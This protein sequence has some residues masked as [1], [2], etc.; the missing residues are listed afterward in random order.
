MPFKNGGSIQG[1]ASLIYEPIPACTYVRRS[2]GI[3]ISCE[4]ESGDMT[5]LVAAGSTEGIAIAADSRRLN[6]DD[7]FN[8]DEAQKV[9]HD[10]SADNGDLVVGWAGTVEIEAGR[11]SFSF[12]KVSEEIWRTL[13]LAGSPEVFFEFATL[14]RGELQ[15]FLDCYVNPFPSRIS[16][17]LL[18][19]QTL[20][21]TFTGGNKI[22]AA[23]IFY[24][25]NGCAQFLQPAVETLTGGYSA[26]RGGSDT[27]WEKRP[28]MDSATLS[29]AIHDADEY[30]QECIAGRGVIPDCAGYGG[31]VHI[32]VVDVIGF[33]WEKAPITIE[34]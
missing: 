28:T 29:E 14:M 3:T 13:R 32:G 27:L 21:G 33:R 15:V 8:T 5:V 20:M 4:L 2:L 12:P 22:C 6:A 1:I 23:M 25:K 31:R 24:V 10:R 16:P 34:P 30:V 26:M 9:W 11:A 19:G 17:N 18:N 7:I